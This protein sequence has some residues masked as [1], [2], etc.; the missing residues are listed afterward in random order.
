MGNYAL[1]ILFLKFFKQLFHLSR[2]GMLCV[3]L[4][5]F[6]S[7]IQL[8]FIIQMFVVPYLFM[9]TKLEEVIQNDDFLFVVDVAHSTGS[10]SLFV[11]LCSL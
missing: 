2:H 7:K 6:T 9:K 3:N 11:A 1:F 4:T 10:R 8:H 5:F